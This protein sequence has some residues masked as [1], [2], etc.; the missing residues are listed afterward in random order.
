MLHLTAESLDNR[1]NVTCTIPSVNFRD[2]LRHVGNVSLRKTAEY[3]D[4]TYFAR[5]LAFYSFEDCLY[6]LL[7]GITDESA[8]IEEQNIHIL[9]LSFRYYFIIVPDLRKKVFSVHLILGTAQSDD[10]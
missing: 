4:F 7:L 5:L 9:L 6:G 2:E 3:K 10:L 8:S 1:F